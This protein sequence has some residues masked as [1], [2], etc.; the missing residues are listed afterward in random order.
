MSNIDK[1]TPESVSNIPI[2]HNQQTDSSRKIS[3][4]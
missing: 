4:A 2:S 3:Y 1:S